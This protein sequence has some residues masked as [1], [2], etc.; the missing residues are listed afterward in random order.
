MN[1]SIIDFNTLIVFTKIIDILQLVINKNLYNQ[2]TENG[3]LH[4]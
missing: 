4:F 3:Y 2:F 1:I